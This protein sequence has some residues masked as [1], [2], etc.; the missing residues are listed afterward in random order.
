MGQSQSDRSQ[1][2]Q[3]EPQAFPMLQQHSDFKVNEGILFSHLPS[4]TL[5]QQDPFLL[6]V[7]KRKMDNGNLTYFK[8]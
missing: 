7:K 4:L 2:S 5:V 6:S 3:G 1:N 8:R